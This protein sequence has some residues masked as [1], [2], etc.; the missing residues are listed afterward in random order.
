MYQHQGSNLFHV[1]IYGEALR[2]THATYSLCPSTHGFRFK[3]NILF[4]LDPYALSATLGQLLPLVDR[5]GLTR[6]G[7]VKYIEKSQIMSWAQPLGPS[8]W[9]RSR[10]DLTK[11][12]LRPTSVLASTTVGNLLMQKRK[13]LYWT[14]CAAH[15]IDLM[16]EDFEKKIPLHQDTIANGKK[17]TTYIYSRTGLISL[18]HK[19]SGGKDL[20]RQAI[21]RFATSYL[22]LGCLN[23]NK[24]S[25]IKL[26][27]S[28]EWQ[29]S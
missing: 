25:L 1:D 4:V 24:G 5:L 7:Y 18:L 15:C 28:S 2:T 19:Y 23:E 9:L 17:I 6:G 22:T 14:P 8:V 21:T 29:S 13:K 12:E 26:F 27:T 11:A 3:G 20:I 10:V 16:F